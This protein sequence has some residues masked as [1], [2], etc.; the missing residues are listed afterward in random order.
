M[1][2][3]AFLLEFELVVLLIG[4]AFWSKWINKHGNN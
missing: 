1:P 3:P 2:R 4:L